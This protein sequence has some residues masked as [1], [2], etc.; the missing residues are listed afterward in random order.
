M[1]PPSKSQDYVE[2]NPKYEVVWQS[3]VTETFIVYKGLRIGCSLTIIWDDDLSYTADTWSKGKRVENRL[4]HMV[5]A[6]QALD[7]LQDGGWMLQRQYDFDNQSSKI[8]LVDAKEKPAFNFKAYP[9]WHKYWLNKIERQAALLPDSPHNRHRAVATQRGNH[10][11][12]IASTYTERTLLVQ[13]LENHP[14]K[15]V[16]EV[17]LHVHKMT[18]ENT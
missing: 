8:N 11:R 10:L 15:S 2:S 17:M 14:D 3:L 9:L 4:L 7:R 12:Q 16:E 5:R 13:E 6:A 18:V 1:S